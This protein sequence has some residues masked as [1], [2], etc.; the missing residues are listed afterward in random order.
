MKRHEERIS[1][2]TQYKI[3]EEIQKRKNKVKCEMKYSQASI[4]E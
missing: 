1:R 4:K 3:Y 2:Q